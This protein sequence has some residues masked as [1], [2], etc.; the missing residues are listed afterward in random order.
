MSIKFEKL[1]N[2]TDKES[3]VKSFDEILIKLEHLVESLKVN[4]PKND[5]G[6]HSEWLSLK[7]AAKYA[8]VSYN[9][10]ITFRHMGLKVCE[11]EGIKRVSRKEIDI[12][13]E[14]HSY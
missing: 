11:I 7:D 13:L 14:S 6:M 12:F 1:N 2:V 5:C 10:F 9:T 4:N 3:L 8:G